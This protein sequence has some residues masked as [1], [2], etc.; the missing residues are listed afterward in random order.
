MVEMA[1]TEAIFHNPIHPYTM[2]LMSAFPSI[3]GEKTELVT[4]PGEPPDLLAPPKACR[5][6]PRCPYATEICRE[7]EPAFKEHGDNH[8]AACWHPG[9]KQ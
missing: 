6:H 2:A 8:Y 4:L 9:G 5:F 3:V 1:S 7:E